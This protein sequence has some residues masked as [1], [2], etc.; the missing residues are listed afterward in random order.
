MNE[1]VKG[2][3]GKHGH[4]FLELGQAH[5]RQADGRG[6]VQLVATAAARVGFWELG[7]EH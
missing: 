2:G 6:F 1:V 4:G 5:R 7:Q 3:F